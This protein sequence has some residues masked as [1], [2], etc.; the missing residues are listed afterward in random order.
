MTLGESEIAIETVDQNLECVLQRMKISLLRGIFLRSHLSF[1]FKPKLPQIGQQ[2][3]ENLQLIGRRKTIELQHDG[4]VER[5][6]IAMP[7]IARYAGEKDVGI[8]SL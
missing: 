4:R 5:S 6:D 2:V 3:S 7:D 8:T 1:S